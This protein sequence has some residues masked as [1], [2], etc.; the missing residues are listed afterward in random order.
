MLKLH[1]KWGPE[2]HDVDLASSSTLSELM[3]VIE[4]NIGVPVEGQKIILSGKSLTSL[5]RE[6]S[7]TDLR[8]K[9]GSKVMILGKRFD[10]Q[11][12]EMYKKVEDVREKSFAVTKRI[13]EISKDVT[14]IENG[15][16]DRK[17]QPEAL[18]SLSKRCKICSEEY[19]KLLEKLDSFTF[20]EHQIQAK[21]KRKS[22][23]IETNSALDRADDL[24]KQIDSLLI[25]IESN[26]S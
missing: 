12:D 11:S 22:V 9:D 16:L 2:K 18:R 1:L 21:M 14:D 25:K 10:P 15:H 24:V 13:V 19:M 3:N 7:L 17:L 6:K 5:D 20:A 8:F 23:V 4:E 26:K